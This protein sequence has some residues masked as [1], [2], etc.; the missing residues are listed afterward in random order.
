MDIY[1]YPLQT[2]EGRPATWKKL[3][4]ISQASANPGS[5]AVKFHRSYHRKD[6]DETEVEMENV[7]KGEPALTVNIPCIGKFSVALV[8][9]VILLIAKIYSPRKFPAV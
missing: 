4:A 2:M 5:M 9:A 8:F 6:D 3:S 7:A 1:Q